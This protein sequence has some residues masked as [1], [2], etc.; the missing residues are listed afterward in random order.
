VNRLTVLYDSGC[1]LCCR[2][3]RWLA[4]QPS[5]VELEFVGAATPH[6]RKRFPHLNPEETK[7]D[8]TVVGDDGSVYRGAKAWLICLW[9]TRRYRAWSLTLGT[10]ALLPSARRLIEWVSRNRHRLRGEDGV[11]TDRT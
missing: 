2:A 1:A 10:P 4:D 9:A 7:E 11:C 3:R 5:F 6:A 8:L